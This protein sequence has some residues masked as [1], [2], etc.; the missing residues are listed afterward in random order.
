MG[1]LTGGLRKVGEKVETGGWGQ[2]RDRILA[3]EMLFWSFRTK[4]TGLAR[5][6]KQ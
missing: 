5:K 4:A 6:E 1:S 3:T 2:S